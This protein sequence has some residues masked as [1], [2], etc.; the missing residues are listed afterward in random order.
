MEG[1]EGDLLQCMRS[2]W[3]F[4]MKERWNIGEMVTQPARWSFPSFFPTQRRVKQAHG[5]TDPG[6]H[7]L[8]TEVR[9]DA[10]AERSLAGYYCVV[11]TYCLPSHRF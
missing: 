5:M 7:A 9:A 10:A 4:I 8:R 1:R 3:R 2:A 11:L 6:K